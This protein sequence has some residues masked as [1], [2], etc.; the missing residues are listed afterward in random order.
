MSPEPHAAFLAERSR[1]GGPGTVSFLQHGSWAGVKQGWEAERLGWFGAAGHQ[2]GA[3]LVLYRRFPGSPRS[4]AYIPEGPVIDWASP[5]LDSWL[6]PLLRHL[7][8]AGAFAV[9][10]GPPLSLRRWGAKTLKAVV[11]PGRRIGDAV[12]DRVD[13]LGATIAERLRETG[14]RRCDSDAQPRH[15]FEVPLAGRSL[16]DVWSG[17]NQEWRRNIKKA[18]RAGV[19]AE[20]ADAGLLPDFHELLK[21]TELRDGFTLGRGLEYFQRQYRVLNEEEPGRMRLY[22]ARYEAEILAAHTMITAGDRVWYQT[23]ASADHRRE[24]RPSHALQWRMMRDAVAQGARVYDMRG[25]PDTLDP[26]DRAFGLMRWKLGTGGEVAESLGEWDLALDGA[27]NRTLHR[28]LRA[29][30]ARR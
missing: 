20:V 4:F 19:S 16:D 8:L 27:V 10:M 17:F 12:P 15:G 1:S 5:E 6:A 11:G 22:V 21:L 29:Y 24:V 25:V 2:I 30:L 13:P 3:A 26:S 23:G 9:R 28:A 18:G 7:R 14:W